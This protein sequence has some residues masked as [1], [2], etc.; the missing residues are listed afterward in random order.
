[1][2]KNA[3]IIVFLY[4][5]DKNKLRFALSDHSPRWGMFPVVLHHNDPCDHVYD[6]CHSNHLRMKKNRAMLN[7]ERPSAA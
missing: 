5:K 4:I 6:L 3:D 7:I 1:M 2:M